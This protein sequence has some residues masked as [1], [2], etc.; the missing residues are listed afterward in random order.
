[1]AFTYISA[2]KPKKLTWAREYERLPEGAPYQL[3]G[4]E[5][6]LSP[7]PT[8]Y[9]QKIC[10]RLFVA[11]HAFVEEHDLGDVTIAPM[12]VHLTVVD[13]YQ[14]DLLFIQKENLPEINWDDR[15]RIVPDMV[16]EVLSPSNRKREIDRKRKIYYETGVSEFWFIDPK[17]QTVEILVN[18]PTGFRTEATLNPPMDLTSPMFPGF[19]LPLERLFKR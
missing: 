10:E 18:T 5:L 9:H 6:V 1:M 2:I 12:D 15:V 16:V 17:K 4:G 8:Y 3:I 14:P 11:L 7:A 19:A 13:V